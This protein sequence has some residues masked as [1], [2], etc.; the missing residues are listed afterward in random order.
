MRTAVDFHTI[1]RQFEKAYQSAMRPLTERLGMAQP[2]LDILLFLANNPGRDT[3]RDICTYRHL[4][5]AIV[6]FHVDHLVREGYLAR[7]SVPGDR[8]KC[9]LVLTEKAAPIVT[10]GRALQTR[11]NEALLRG[12]TAEELEIFQRCFQTVERNTAALAGGLQADQGG[13]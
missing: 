9:R 6:S 7:E 11:F 3:A 12:L 5:P 10:E 1:S 8:R 13:T 4:K 2:A